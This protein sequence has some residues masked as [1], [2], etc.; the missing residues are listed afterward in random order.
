MLSV[1]ASATRLEMVTL[2]DTDNQPS[3]KAIYINSGGVLAV[4]TDNTATTV[5]LNV[6]AGQELGVKA[7]H[8][9]ATGTTA[10]AVLMDWD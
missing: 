1:F 3:H 7:T 8:I 10:T 5:L 4:S 2:S 6:V 9:M